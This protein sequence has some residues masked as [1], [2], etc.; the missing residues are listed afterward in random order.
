MSRNISATACWS[1][2]ATRGRTRTTP[3]GRCAR[4]WH[5]AQAIAALRSPAAAARSA[6]RH[7]HRPRRRRRSLGRRGKEQTRVVGETPNLAARLQGMAGARRDRGERADARA[8]RRRF[9]TARPRARKLKGIRR[10]GHP[11][12][13]VAASAALAPASK[14]GTSAQ[15]TRWSAATSELALLLER[16][17][18]RARA[19]QVVLLIGR[20][21][22][23]QVAHPALCASVLAGEPHAGVYNQCSPYY[24][25]TARST[26]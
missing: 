7:R 16:W 5:R 24:S 26:R 14:R 25:Q 9:R 4:R 19:G 20:G 13:R 10:A 17:G 21:R 2:S 1:T 8:A 23:R 18:R 6:H 15:L 3:S 11:R 12:W 22:H